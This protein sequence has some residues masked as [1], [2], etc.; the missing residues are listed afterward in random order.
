VVSIGFGVLLFLFG[1]A[2]KRMMHGVK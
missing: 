1:G 2:V